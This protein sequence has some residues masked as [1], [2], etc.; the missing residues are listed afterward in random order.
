MFQWNKFCKCNNNNICIEQIENCKEYDN[1]NNCKTCQDN[2]AFKGNERNKCTK[3]SEFDIYYTKDGGISYYECDGEGPEHIK[4]CKK[5]I[6]DG[7]SSSLECTECKKNY[8]ILDQETNKCLSKEIMNGNNLYFYLNDTHIKKCSNAI[9]NC[10][11]CENG[12]KCTKCNNS[13][14]LKNKDTNKCYNKNEIM[15]IDEY[16]LDENKITYYSCNNS[17]YN[18]IEHCKKC[19]NKNTCSLCNDEFTFINRNKTKCYKI[20]EL[21]NRY[22][23]DPDDISNYKSCNEININCITCSAFNI[24]LSCS[25]GFGLYKDRKTCVNISN[26]NYYK[27][28]KNNLYYPCNETLGC[29][30]CINEKTCIICDERKFALINNTCLN[31]SELGNK[32]YKDEIILEYKLC[33]EGIL[34]CETCYSKNQCIKCA[35]NYTKV[36]HENNSCHLISDLGNKYIQAPYDETNY[37]KCSNYINNCLL[38]NSSQCILCEQNYIFINIVK[39]I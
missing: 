32:Y 3:K 11:E 37:L 35:S 6:Y 23:K 18:S 21:N 4:N 10:L 25:N 28:G 39:L 1:N 2:Y 12:R 30:Q 36:N 29:I 20:K 16:Y 17:E 31:I 38:C 34:N 24:C 19:T 8:I 7:T 13:Y 26:N 27:K 5:C 9:K 15:P 33:K 22:Y 14:F